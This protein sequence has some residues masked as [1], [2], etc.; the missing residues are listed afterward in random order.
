MQEESIRLLQEIAT[1][2]K[3]IEEEM[4]VVSS[5]M[6]TIAQFGQSQAAFFM[7]AHTV[8]QRESEHKQA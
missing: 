3:Q 5:Q 4:A 8:F 1:H 2:A 7:A 6:E